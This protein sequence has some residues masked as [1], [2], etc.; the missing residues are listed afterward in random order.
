MQEM[1]PA[2]IA[3]AKDRA[4]VDLSCESDIAAQVVQRIPSE[5]SSY[6]LDRAEFKIATTGCGRRVLLTVACGRGQ[7]CSALRQNATVERVDSK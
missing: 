3:A 6:G 5:A 7:I 1:E 2:A 4:R